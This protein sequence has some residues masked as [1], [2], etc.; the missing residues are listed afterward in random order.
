MLTR[1]ALHSPTN[2]S[3]RVPRRLLAIGCLLVLV[4]LAGCSS[5]G[6]VSLDPVDDTDLAREASR[7]VD[8][9]GDEA[10]RVVREAVETGAANATSRNDPIDAGDNPYPY[11]YDGAHYELSSTVV[12]EETVYAAEVAV[13]YNATDVAGA[14]AVRFE[15]L[16]PADRRAV[17][18]V[19]PPETDHRTEGYDIGVGAVYTPGQLAN[20]TLADRDEPSEQV[21]VVDGERYRVRVDGVKEDTRYTY[22]Y[23]VEEVFAS[24][25]AYADHLRTEHQFTLSG[26]PT[27]EREVLTEARNG[28]YHADGEDDAAFRAVVERFRSH[29]AVKG[30]EY[31][32]DWLVRWQGETYWVDLRFGAYA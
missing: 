5:P 30:D 20:S 18:E 9:G 21:V 15:D 25:A 31:G 26:L 8:P 28:T 7:D 10:D 6:S 14:D 3:R 32:G 19:L 4:A 11:R 16:P 22:R 12:D 27:D 1:V 29:E 17:D 24:D 2:G 13:D 23:T